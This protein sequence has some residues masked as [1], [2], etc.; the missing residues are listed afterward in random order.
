[1]YVCMYVCMYIYIY[2][3]K[4]TKQ[5]ENTRRR[6]KMFNLK[7]IGL[8]LLKPTIIGT[9]SILCSVVFLVNVSSG[10]SLSPSTEIKEYIRCELLHKH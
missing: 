8:L 9:S 2:N 10:L 4:K 3:K 6:R 5:N 7:K 1:M